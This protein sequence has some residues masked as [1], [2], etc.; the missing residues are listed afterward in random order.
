MSVWFDLDEAASRL[1]ALELMRR[2][3]HGTPAVFADPAALD[4]G[5]ILFGPMALKDGEPAQIAERLRALLAR[6]N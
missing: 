6:A 5:R 1:G 4:Q 3:E 2:L